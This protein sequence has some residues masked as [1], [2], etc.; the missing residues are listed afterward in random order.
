M[1]R[2]IPFILLLLACPL[3]MLAMGVVAWFAAKIRPGRE[4][5]QTTSRTVGCRVAE[6]KGNDER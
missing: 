6:P 3:S 2:D 5:R 1:M 4:E